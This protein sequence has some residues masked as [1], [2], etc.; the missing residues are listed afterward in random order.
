[1]FKNPSAFLASALKRDS[2]P[3]EN[4]Q[5]GAVFRSGRITLIPVEKYQIINCK[6][7]KT[8]ENTVA[9]NMAHDDVERL[10]F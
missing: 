6:R 1:M 8:S 10:R 5:D 7:I 3:P 2:H 4:I 9:K